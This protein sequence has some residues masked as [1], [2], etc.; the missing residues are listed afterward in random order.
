MNECRDPVV[1]A[2]IS[3]TI[4]LIDQKSIGTKLK[5]TA[6]ALTLFKSNEHK[7]KRKTIKSGFTHQI[8]KHSRLSAERKSLIWSLCHVIV[9]MHHK[10]KK[11]AQFMGY[12]TNS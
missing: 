2:S 9:M 10:F 7:P 6:P 12:K 3:T 5:N 4:F 1:P 11:L 8:F